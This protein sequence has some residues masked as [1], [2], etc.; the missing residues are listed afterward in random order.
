MYNHSANLPPL[1]ASTELISYATELF[2][3]DLMTIHWPRVEQ[4]NNYGSLNTAIY[5]V[6]VVLSVF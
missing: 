3:F 4:F 2:S 1:G 5:S 6:K